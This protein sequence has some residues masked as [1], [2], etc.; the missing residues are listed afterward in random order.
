MTSPPPMMKDIPSFGDTS[1]VSGL[2]SEKSNFVSTSKS[3][4]EAHDVFMEKSGLLNFGKSLSLI[5]DF[6][7]D[8][9]NDY[10]Q[11]VGLSTGE[12]IKSDSDLALFH[13]KGDLKMRRNLLGEDLLLH[14]SSSPTIGGDG[15]VYACIGSNAHAFNMDGTLEWTVGL[16]DTCEHLVTPAVTN[17]GKVYMAANDRVVAIAYSQELDLLSIWDL[18]NNTGFDGSML[19]TKQVTGL[20]LMGDGSIL[21]NAGIAGLYAVA[22]D[23]S[24]LWS[25][26]GDL[27]ST[28][29]TFPSGTFCSDQDKLCYFHFSP[30]VDHCDGSV[31]IVHTN[32]WLYAI[33]GWNPN[34]KW[35]YDIKSSGNT[36]VAGVTA[37]YNGRVYVAT[38]TGVL[39]TLDT[40]TGQL[41]WQVKVGP[42][43]NRTCFPKLDSAGQV[44]L[45]SLDGFL[46]VI[47]SS[48]RRVKKYLG[49]WAETS[50]IHSCPYIDCAKKEIF[51]A[52]VSVGMKMV[53]KA[54][55]SYLAAKG[56][57]FF[58]LDAYSGYVLLS[59]YFPGISIANQDGMLDATLLLSVFATNY[60]LGGI[61]DAFGAYAGG[62]KCT[63]VSSDALEGVPAFI[64]RSIEPLYIALPLT[65][66]VLAI[67]ILIWFLLRKRYERNHMRSGPPEVI[68]R[69]ILPDFQDL[70]RKRTMSQN[71][72][73]RLELLLKNNPASKQLQLE[74]NE[75]VEDLYSNEWILSQF[76][77]NCRNDTDLEPLLQEVTSDFGIFGT[78]SHNSISPSKGLGLSLNPGSFNKFVIPSKPKKVGYSQTS[79]N[80]SME[81]EFGSLNRASLRRS[82]AN[83]LFKA[84]ESLSRFN[85]PEFQTT[86]NSFYGVSDLEN[87]YSPSLNSTEISLYEQQNTDPF[88]IPE[89]VNADS[90]E[91]PDSQTNLYS[92]TSYA[93]QNVNYD[94]YESDLDIRQYDVC[95]TYPKILQEDMMDENA[96]TAH[97]SL[98]PL[99]KDVRENMIKLEP[100]SGS[101]TDENMEHEDTDNNADRFILNAEVER[102][103]VHVSSALEV[104][105]EASS[106]NE[107]M[108]TPPIDMNIFEQGD[109]EL[110]SAYSTEPEATDSAMMGASEFDFLS[111]RSKPFH[112]IPD[113]YPTSES[114]VEDQELKKWNGVQETLHGDQISSF[115]DDEITRYTGKEDTEGYARDTQELRFEEN[116]SSGEKLCQPEG[117]SS[118]FGEAMNL[119]NLNL[120]SHSE[121][122]DP[123]EGNDVVASGPQDFNPGKTESEKLVESTANTSDASVETPAS[124]RSESSSQST[125]RSLVTT[126]VSEPAESLNSKASTIT[127]V[128]DDESSDNSDKSEQE[129]ESTAQHDRGIIT[130]LGPQRMT[131]TATNISD[132]HN[133]PPAIEDS[134]RRR[135]SQQAPRASASERQ[136][137]VAFGGLVL[138][139]SYFTSQSQERVGSQQFSISRL[140]IAEMRSLDP[141]RSILDDRTLS[142]GSSMASR[143]SS[144]IPP[145]RASQDYEGKN[146]S[147]EPS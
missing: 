93:T 48:G 64:G 123:I 112:I 91:I 8:M 85:S 136:N 133:L 114:K 143:S 99:I 88:L 13:C 103:S 140:P 36:S 139:G 9:V 30:A 126:S 108:D 94:D 40:M 135:L 17:D 95:D 57:T 102:P 43:T 105:P 50:I 142:Q 20:T 34:V 37:G 21:I 41:L 46:Y 11:L 35:R 144:R 87:G 72:V 132:W 66:F 125:P 97:S 80:T 53:T 3:T 98:R 29:A 28:D 65:F 31:Y 67:L 100:Q 121:N 146:I 56:V 68:D 52:Q 147:E 15:R 22:E 131:R 12:N 16:N 115:K 141:R 10:S 117:D 5:S 78:S 79:F 4:A 127:D 62:W 71:K 24:P 122:Q 33:D 25:T 49:S 130:P 23:G 129:G 18:F 70:C 134:S 59:K 39:S 19:G 14:Q 124:S 137:T 74:L 27:S 106:A 45:G 81:V 104:E 32:G 83:P 128:S 101:A 119:S 38:T 63:L 82:S 58:V 120:V 77:P 111:D 118:S 92:N 109:G 138:P 42:L 145:G 2:D 60:S 75:A 110:L 107:A 84:S 73:I 61:C 76:S 55:V 7:D 6:S 90:T 44:V 54:A 1:V 47:S 96:L 86:H 89:A 51:V 116:G 26:N 113:P 69:H